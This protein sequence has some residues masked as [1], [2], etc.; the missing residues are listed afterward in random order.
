MPREGR[1]ELGHEPVVKD[2]RRSPAEDTLWGI[3][4]VDKANNPE[5]SEHEE[6]MAELEEL[7]SSPTFDREGVVSDSVAMERA[8]EGGRC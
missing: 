7:G 1:K 5:E 8:H 3:A 4:L 6:N 2:Q